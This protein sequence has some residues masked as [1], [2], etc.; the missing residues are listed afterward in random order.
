VTEW[1]GGCAY[2]LEM[3]QRLVPPVAYS[4]CH[5]VE[6]KSGGARAPLQQHALL[7]HLR[8]LQHGVWFILQRRAPHEPQTGF[9]ISHAAQASRE[10]GAQGELAERDA[11]RVNAATSVEN[12]LSWVAHGGAGATCASVFPAFAASFTSSIAC[13]Q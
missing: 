13:T 12:M 2:C 4:H 6:I 8:V 1:R 9:D 10:Q 11:R 7:Q 3:V 5:A